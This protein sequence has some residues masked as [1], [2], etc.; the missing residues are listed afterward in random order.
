M[1]VLL[2]LLLLVSQQLAMTHV[3]V[4]ADEIGV[5]WTQSGADDHEPSKPKLADHICSH[6]A[7]S[8]QL[9]YAIGSSGYSFAALDVSYGPVRTD[10]TRSA[11]QQSVRA[12]H[13][14]APPL[15]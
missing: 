14:R 10:Q 3:Y 15:A 1:H 6:C 8:V 7:A 12:F 11:S 13:A 5:S 4:H 2:S 9:A